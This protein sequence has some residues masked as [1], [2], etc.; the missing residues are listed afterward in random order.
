MVL[1]VAC[2]AVPWEGGTSTPETVGPLSFGMSNTSESGLEVTPMAPMMRW[3]LGPTGSQHEAIQSNISECMAAAGYDY[4]AAPFYSGPSLDS[5]YGFISTSELD[6]GA[7]GQNPGVEGLDEAGRAGWAAALFGQGRDSGVFETVEDGDSYF[8]ASSGGCLDAA[9]IEVL[10]ENRIER[11]ALAF[12]IQNLD[13]YA[14]TLSEL[15]VR[16]QGA[17][18]RW[19]E[20]VQDGGYHVETLEDLTVLLGDRERIDLHHKCLESSHLATVWNAVDIEVQQGLLEGRSDLI[21]RWKKQLERE[22]DLLP[23]DN[24]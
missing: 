17:L 12:T 20:C 18:G 22:A 14:Y 13:V 19:A 4:H 8:T 2:S 16:V 5:R 7:G 9:E 6:G 11:L 15:D 23:Q 1:L 21:Q 10:G 24:N 3:A